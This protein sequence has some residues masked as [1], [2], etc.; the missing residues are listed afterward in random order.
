MYWLIGSVLFILLLIIRSNV[1]SYLSKRS[2]IVHLLYNSTDKSYCVNL[3]HK[4]QILRTDECDGT[5]EVLTETDQIGS[6]KFYSSEEVFNEEEVNNL[7]VEYNK[8]LILEQKKNGQMLDLRRRV[9]YFKCTENNNNN[10]TKGYIG[11]SIAFYSKD[12][13]GRGA[14]T[15]KRNCNDQLDKI[16]KPIPVSNWSRIK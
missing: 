13:F 7:L 3:Y 6:M 16:H 8:R 5:K 11:N 2:G 14:A 10:T 1:K 4:G 15:T 12:P 9:N